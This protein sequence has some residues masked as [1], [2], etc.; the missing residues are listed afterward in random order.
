LPFSL[1]LD[2]RFGGQAWQLQFLVDSGI[3]PM[4]AIRAATSVAATLI[5]YGDRIGTIER[6]KLA[7][8]ISVQGNPIEHI[9]AMRHIRLVMKD[10]VRYD[11]LSWR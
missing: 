9:Q 10:G 1:G 8:L 5:G 7:D 3:S 4:D 11:R 6:G 2:A